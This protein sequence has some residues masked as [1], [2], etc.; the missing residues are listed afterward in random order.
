[1]AV[2]R[3]SA[4][5]AGRPAACLEAGQGPPLVLVHGAGGRGEVWGPQLADLSDV[6]RVI[7]VDLPGHGGTG[8]AGCRRIDD[9]ATWVVG[10]L[11]ALALDRV[12]LG[13][14]SM[15]GAISQTIAR[16]R[17]ERLRGL[18]LVGTGARLRVAPRILELF[19]AGSPVGAELV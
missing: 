17:P 18:V 6:A 5:V 13:G 1:M 4:T 3:A 7:A 2:A 14:H 19:G 15:G 10:L 12:V 16:A 11:D 8:G 9:Y